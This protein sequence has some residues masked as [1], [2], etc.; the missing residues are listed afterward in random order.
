M[1]IKTRLKRLANGY[2]TAFFDIHI[3]GIRR[4]EYTGIKFKAI[5]NTIQEREDRKTKLKLVQVVASK[6]EIELLNSL[7]NLEERYNPSADFVVYIDNFIAY[8]PVQEIKKFRTV[9]K[10]FVDY[11]GKEQVPCFEITESFLR[12]FVQYLEKRLNGESPANYFAKLKQILRAAVSDGVLPK[13]PADGIK[14]KKTQ[15]LQKDVLNYSE[16]A[17]IAQTPIGNETVKKAFL[18]CIFTGL[19]YCDV[20]SLKWENV[21]NDRICI[22]QKKTKVPLTIPLSDSARNQLSEQGNSD[23]LVFKLPSHTSCQKWAKRLV[24]AAGIDKKISWHSCRHSFGTNLIAH[25][26]DV[27]ITSKLLG[28]TS[29]VNTQR[30][31]KVNDEMKANAISKLPD[32]L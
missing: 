1:R 7:N 17:L 8:H 18:F 31:V 20:S 19:R 21:L 30:Y 14:V 23:E 16:I 15:F 26:V 24:K 29:L 22:V 32:I 27:S 2:E 3:N 28:H 5:P 11:A 13:N 6:R 25:G 10:K 4:F 9:R 12:K